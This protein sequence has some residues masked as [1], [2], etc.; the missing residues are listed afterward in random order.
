MYIFLYSIFNV[1]SAGDKNGT[2]DSAGNL[3]FAPWRKS[4]VE[5]GK[6][7]TCAL[8]NLY[9]FPLD[10]PTYNTFYIYIYIHVPLFILDIIYIYIFIYAYTQK[11][12][13]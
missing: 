9:R 12:I 3:L 5:S 10:I 1:S 6:K 7:G 4:V 11:L 2:G 8:G 13:I